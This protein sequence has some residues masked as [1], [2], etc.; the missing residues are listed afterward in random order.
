MEN[1]VIIGASAKED[2][3]SYKAQEM[4][5]AHN[6]TPI[7]VNPYG[8]E[9]QGVTCFTS[10]N[11]ISEPIDTV[12]LYVAPKRLSG[13][14]NDIIALKPKRIIFNPGTESK[15]LMDK[16]TNANIEVVEACTLVMLSTNQ[17]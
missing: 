14:L 5:V 7:P 6:H 3:Y 17:F 8:G 16:V 9:V 10:V 15:E 13:I 11:D 2:R 12:T 1:V 4:L